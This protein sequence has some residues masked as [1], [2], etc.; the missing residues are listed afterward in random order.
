MALH[1]VF[2][3][4]TYYRYTLNVFNVSI[5]IFKF[6]IYHDQIED[7]NGV[8]LMFGCDIMRLFQKVRRINAS[9]LVVLILTDTIRHITIILDYFR[10]HPS[11][12]SDQEARR[13]S[14]T[15]IDPANLK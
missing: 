13:V 1:D 8:K 14:Q 6:H 10:V 12:S 3:A 2:M 9:L 11:Q 15:A 4:L 7:L 5:Y